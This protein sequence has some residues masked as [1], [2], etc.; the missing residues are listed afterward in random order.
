MSDN[1]RVRRRPRGHVVHDALTRA[2]SVAML[3]IGVALCVR[4]SLLSIVLGL[5]FLAA[6]AGRLY[7]Q[8]RV[9]SGREGAP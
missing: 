3:A 8:L 7:V 1:D 6:G 9:R 4:G 2:M 5:L